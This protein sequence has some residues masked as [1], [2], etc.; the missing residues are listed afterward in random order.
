M[1][2]V[3]PLGPV[4]A[5][6]GLSHRLE[7]LKR[8]VLR[9]DRRKFANELVDSGFAVKFVTSDDGKDMNCTVCGYALVSSVPQEGWTARGCSARGMQT[10]LKVSGTKEW[11]DNLAPMYQAQS[12]FDIVAAAHLQTAGH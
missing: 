12:K 11:C 2:Y 9:I 1:K 10:L 3:A 8:I 4:G 5:L 7:G 6:K